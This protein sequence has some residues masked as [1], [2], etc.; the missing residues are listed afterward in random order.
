M[1][2]RLFILAINHLL[3]GANWAGARL[4]PF[5][6]RQARIEMPPFVLAFEI[7]AEGRMRACADA[8][9]TDVVV[10]LPADTPFLLPHGLTRIMA[11]ASVEGNAEFATELSFV[12]RHLRWDAEE[13]LAGVIG[14]IA[15][16]RL[17]TGASR[18]L[19]WQR[20]SATNLGANVAEYM[21]RE[22]QLLVT[23]QEFAVFQAELQQLNNAL[24]QLE[25]RFRNQ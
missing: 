13:D 7:D 3:A 19:D 25:K 10:R 12:F 20:Q 18:L 24:I 8:E 23:T 4:R 16:R 2:E 21:S 17:V 14:D 15:A 11:C 22:Q 5:A 6:G 9:G 1:V